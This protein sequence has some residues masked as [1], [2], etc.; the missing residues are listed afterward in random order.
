MIMGLYDIPKKDIV[1][2]KAG[3]PKKHTPAVLLNKMA[4]I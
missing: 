4:I 1:W 3:Q 2:I